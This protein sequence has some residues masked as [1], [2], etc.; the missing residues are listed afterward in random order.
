MTPPIFIST[1]LACASKDKSR[2]R[3]QL[4]TS[5]LRQLL[6]F[7]GRDE[8]TPEEFNKEFIDD[9]LSWA[10]KTGSSPRTIELYRS[11][12]RSLL[13]ETYPD[14]EYD[15]KKAFEKSPVRRCAATRGMNVEQLRMLNQAV[16]NGR[17]DL[18]QA[19]DLFMFCVYCGG[20]DYNAAKSLTREVLK[21]DYLEL[22]T[23]LNVPLNLNIRS[24]LSM[25]E[26]ED[27]SE[28]FPFCKTMTELSYAGKLKEI[29][30]RFHLP[31][32][33]ERHA[34][35]KAWV[36]A[37]K[38]V[39]VEIEVMAA[40]AY[41]RVEALTNY[42]G[43]ASNDAEKIDKA[44]NEVCRAVVD[45]TEHW[46][47]MKLRDRVAP[48]RIQQLLLENEKYPHLRQLQTYYP[49][50]DIKVKVGNKWKRDTKAF[51]KGVL[52]FR[53]RK[54]YVNQLFSL[55]HN[56]AWIFRQ[57]NALSSPYAVISQHD[58]ENFQ[59]AISQFTDD[60][61][62]SIVE[63]NDITVGRTVRVLSGP[64]EGTEGI[65]EG[66]ELDATVPEMRN[67]Y[68]RYTASNSMRVRIKV[69][70]SMVEVME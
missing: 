62:V 20:L 48:D 24:I 17:E 57:S 15:I 33:R 26:V 27:R 6:V 29:A 63:N 9:Y 69:S 41:K 38:E 18:T 2:S 5:A 64:F 53:T 30:M 55:V 56:S 28:L 4:R 3:V 1:L 50:E 65:V 21:G 36:S 70:E 19:R 67:F 37:A 46:Y 10:V 61:V 43:T 42:T 32:I 7:V 23:G 49:M 47:A 31:K 25:Y 51:I 68:I 54:R 12:L 59:R 35:A 34:E 39:K 66:E 22:P 11:A 60:I 45:N 13:I 58:M 14:A 52:F 8:V 16:F 40:C 44:I